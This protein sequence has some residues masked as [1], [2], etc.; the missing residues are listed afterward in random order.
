VIG[1]GRQ[2]PGVQTRTEA[3]MIPRRILVA[4]GCALAASG[5]L[6]GATSVTA[7]VPGGNG[8]I[9]FVSNAAGQLDVYVVNGDG[10]GRT[11]LTLGSPGID[12]DPA[13]S[14]DGSRIAFASNRGGNSDV[15]VMDATGS[16]IV[17]LTDSP[18]EDSDPAW[19]PD[20]T[21][22]A[23]VS[24][25]SQNAGD[26]GESSE[27]IWVMNA[28]GTDPVRLTT[29]V[30]FD[31]D[32]AWSP[33]GK[34]IAW[35]R[36]DGSLDIWIMNADGSGQVRLTT[37]HGDDERPSWSPDGSRILFSSQ[38]DG[39]SGPA[40]RGGGTGRIYAM[41]PDGSDQVAL[42]TSI[43]DRDPAF[44]PDGARFV[45][46]SSRGGGDLELYLAATD[47]PGG[48]TQITFDDA[49][50][51]E[52]DWQPAPPLPLPAAGEADPCTIRGS[53]NDDVIIGTAGD[54]VICGLGGND[55]LQGRRGNDRLL[56]GEGDDTLVGGAGADVLTGG[57]GNDEADGG[58]G[59]DRCRAESSTGCERV[60]PR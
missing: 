2:E 57:P 29:N 28:D 60:R 27:E 1:H 10:S 4:A 33:D 16:N 44:S 32:P 40:I 47:G 25:R 43:V 19:S 49:N 6:L 59:R 45:F 38:R 58:P 48:P 11:N 55:E 5:A 41:N 20:G 51:V 42:T 35:S 30:L 31:D 14:P 50:D 39:G 54:D 17:K 56:G 8:K 26:I 21:R 52:P 23:F 37:T 22:I 13:W 9:A 46:A 15:Y 53:V 7:T 36:V 24:T 3:V 34:R 18:F 12:Q